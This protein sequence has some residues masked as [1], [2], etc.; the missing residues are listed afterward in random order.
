MDTT[1]ITRNVLI[2][3]IYIIGIQLNAQEVNIS[4]NELPQSAQTFIKAHF[5]DLKVLKATKE[6]GRSEKT[7]YEIYFDN[8]VKI[9]FDNKGEWKEVDGNNVQIPTAYLPE[10]INQYVAKNFPSQEITKAEKSSGRYE[11][12]LDNGI[13]LKFN[14]KGKFLRSDD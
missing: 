13:D 8:G 9:E 12:E 2:I 14:S 6:T 7:E 10:E 1:L 5:S 11:L 4:T 3:V